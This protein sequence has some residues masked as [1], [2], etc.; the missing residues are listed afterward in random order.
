MNLANG[1][2]LGRIALIPVFGYLWWRG[3]HGAALAVFALAAA[4]DLADG[5]AARVLDQRTRTGQILDPVAD[6]LMLLTSFLVAAH[7]R[8]VP[9][10]LA[11]LVIGRDG[12]LLSGA[13]SFRF[14]LRG[15]LDPQHWTPTRLGKYAAFSQVLTIG[16]ALLHRVTDSET[17]RP[18][19]G[20]LVIM[21]A[22]LT[23]LSG[24]QYVAAGLTALRSGS[25]K[26]TPGGTA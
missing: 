9:V 2:T 4:S 26:L 12:V 17:L 15:R 1:I 7:N 14:L 11:V 24:I 25:G 22:T 6:K 21:C 18:F 13:L 16:L 5:F 8:A 3:F 23:T 20:T 19:V 10:W